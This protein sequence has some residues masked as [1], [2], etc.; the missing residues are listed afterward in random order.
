MIFIRKFIIIFFDTI[1]DFNDIFIFIVLFFG[2]DH[3]EKP[4]KEVSFHHANENLVDKSFLP[5]AR[6]RNKS[7]NEKSKCLWINSD[8]IYVDAFEAMN[9]IDSVKNVMPC[10]DND[11]KNLSRYEFELNYDEEHFFRC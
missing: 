2:L 10:T 5:I 8:D 11:E 1:D 6:S 4:T 3:I 7:S 9:Y